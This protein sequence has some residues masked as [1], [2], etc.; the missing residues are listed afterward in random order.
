MIELSE[1]SLKYWN[2]WRNIRITDELLAYSLWYSNYRNNTNIP[3][4]SRIWMIPIKCWI[5]VDYSNCRQMIKKFQHYWN[6]SKW[7][8]YSY[9]SGHSDNLSNVLKSIT[10]IFHYSRFRIIKLFEYSLNYS[11]IWRIIRIF[12]ELFE[13]YRI[14]FHRFCVEIPHQTHYENRST[15][16]LGLF[17]LNSYEFPYFHPQYTHNFILLG[18]IYM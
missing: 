6:H 11:N 5:F 7:L 12:D 10:L 2:I 4:S 18:H 8:E 14:H 3:I 15:W 13:N 9:Y 17:W 1:Y 16:I